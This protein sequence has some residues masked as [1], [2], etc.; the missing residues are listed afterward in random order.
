MTWAC[1]SAA[2]P[3]MLQRLL[4]QREVLMHSKSTTVLLR[5]ETARAR[6]AVRQSRV[7]TAML[8]MFVALPVAAATAN[9]QSRYLL[10]P[11]AARNAS[12]DGTPTLVGA[13]VTMYGGSLGGMAGLRFGGA[14]DVRS[15]AGSTTT[16]DTE[17]AWGMDVDA[18]LSP[19]RLPVIGPLLGGFLP[20]VFSG[21][22]V[23]GVRRSDG[24]GGQSIVTSYG[25]GV[26][27]TIAGLL[28]IDTEA[29]RRIPVSWT[30]ASSDGS[31]ASGIAN[32][33]WE[34]RLGIS[35]GFGGQSAPDGALGRRP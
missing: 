32:R 13:T 18:V 23:E 1:E 35:I 10:S 33:G 11:F 24:T 30:G 5:W 20:T 28:S 29:R 16:T 7:G 31:Q 9:A 12:L 6:R 26:T 3:G 25:A 4:P 14:Y 22:G 34:Y 21:I 8:T 15:L 17:R 27:R 19:A 2:A